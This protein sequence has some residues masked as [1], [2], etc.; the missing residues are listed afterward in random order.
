M[1]PLP[2]GRT[3]LSLLERISDATRSAYDRDRRDSPQR[4]TGAPDGLGPDYLFVENVA[5]MLSCNVD[6][7]RRIPRS[8]LPASKVG[9]R[10]I[11]AR[12][13]V[14]AFIQLRR[15]AGAAYV[16][17]RKPVQRVANSVEGQSSQGVGFDPVAYVKAAR[18]E[19]KR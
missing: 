14:N 17:G 15:D 12:A 10:L 11:Y 9:S 7:V 18:K 16:T 1:N 4:F 6:F 5:R 2:P 8:E 3:L 13:E 19:I